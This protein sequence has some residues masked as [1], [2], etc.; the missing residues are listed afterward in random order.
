MTYGKCTSEESENP[1]LGRRHR[2]KVPQ[3]GVGRG[4]IGRKI[5]TALKEE[6]RRAGG[7]DSKRKIDKAE[8]PER[9][10]QRVLNTHE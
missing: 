2:P 1:C 10:E 9:A 5:I 4:T 6:R 3:I 8:P 7:A